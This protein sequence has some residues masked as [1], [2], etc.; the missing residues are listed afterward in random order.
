MLKKIFTHLL[1]IRIRKQFFWDI[2]VIGVCLHFIKIASEETL[3]Q[4]R[5]ILPRLGFVYYFAVHEWYIKTY[6]GFMYI[7]LKTKETNLI[8]S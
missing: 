1:Q 6:K 3:F 8:T 4:Y 7:H 2:V 5:D